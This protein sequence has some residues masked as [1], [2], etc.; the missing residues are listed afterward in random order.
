M[1]TECTSS[2]SRRWRSSKKSFSSNAAEPY[3]EPPTAIGRRGL[4][5]GDP[6]LGYSNNSNPKNE[7]YSCDELCDF[8]YTVFSIIRFLKIR[9]KIAFRA[10]KRKTTRKIRAPREKT[11]KKSRFFARNANFLMVFRAECDFSRFFARSAIFS[12]F[13]ARNA[14]FSR[15]F[16]IRIIGKTI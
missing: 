3:W 5:R 9:K 4:S 1:R 6:T 11:E 16:R 14:I 8:N 15:F 10:K 2:L 13:F 7:L 12:R